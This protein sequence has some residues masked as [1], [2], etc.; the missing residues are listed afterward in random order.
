MKTRKI[1]V[2]AGL[3]T[4]LTM[5]G[6]MLPT[7]AAKPL[8]PSPVTY[9]ALG[10]SFAAGYGAGIPIN[11]YGQ[12]A[13]AYPVLLAGGL[14]NL[15]FL[16]AVGA[17]TK[18]EEVATFDV[19]QQIPF[20]P[21]ETQQV[22][23]TV[24][25]NDLGFVDK[26]TACATYPAACALTTGELAKLVTLTEDLSETIASIH[27]QAPAA[28]IYVT[29]YPLLFQATQTLENTGLCV[30]GDRPNTT[31]PVPPSVPLVITEIQADAMDIAAVALNTAI[32]SAIVGPTHRYAKYVDVTAAF[33]GHGL[34]GT[35]TSLDPLVGLPNPESYINEVHVTVTLTESGPVSGVSLANG[36]LHPTAAGQEAYADAISTK[37]FK[38]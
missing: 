4:T 28:T 29:G 7:Q 12:S 9:S 38:N 34:C 11:A 27:E 24:G 25:G 14:N 22:T 35:P 3:V 2:L 32:R 5:T 21:E 31:G 13:G 20:I 8:P 15:T 37:G 26:A 19:E 23:V 6:A 18:D 17:T 1:A 33:T 30:I 10:D 16:A 36:P